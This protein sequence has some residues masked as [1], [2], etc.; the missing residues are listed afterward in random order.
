MKCSAL[1]PTRT[2]RP[3]QGVSAQYPAR[4]AGYGTTL[5]SLTLEET[6]HPFV[7]QEQPLRSQ[8]PGRVKGAMSLLKANYDD[9][10]AQPI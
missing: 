6:D 9:M 3:S 1:D 7:Q 2:T 5:C 4:H 8:T 10:I